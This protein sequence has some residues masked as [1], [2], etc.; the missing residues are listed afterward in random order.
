MILSFQFKV[1]KSQ[2]QSR[3]RE[4]LSV[5]VRLRMRVRLQVGIVARLRLGLRLT[6]HSETIQ[7]LQ[8]FFKH[9]TTNS[10]EKLL[11]T[12]WNSTLSADVLLTKTFLRLL[13]TFN[14]LETLKHLPNRFFKPL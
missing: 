1:S 8:T 3:A 7:T 9:F 6:S 13:L 11:F 4:G 10:R 2:S 14:T 5:G 12:M